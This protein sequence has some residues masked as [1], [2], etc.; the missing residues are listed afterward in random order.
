M[1][2]LTALAG[3]LEMR[4]P[5]TFP[6]DCRKKYV[7]VRFCVLSG[8]SLDSCSR[9]GY[10][11]ER[12]S[13]GRVVSCAVQRNGLRDMVDIGGVWFLASPGTGIPATLD[14]HEQREKTGLTSPGSTMSLSHA[15]QSG[16]GDRAVTQARAWTVGVFGSRPARSS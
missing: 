8:F 3:V 14:I 4:S 11:A 1:L 7:A 2:R 9:D 6:I 5:S 13:L 12:E 16:R 10:R 15:A